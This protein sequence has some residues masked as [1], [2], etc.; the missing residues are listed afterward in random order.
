MVE[1]TKKSDLKAATESYEVLKDD[2]FPDLTIGLIHGRMKGEEKHAIMTDFRDGKL[3]IIAAT[4]VV[5]VGVDIPSATIMAVEHAERFGLS[6]LHQLRGR[7]GRSK[8][9]SYCFLLTGPKV[10]NEAKRRIEAMT[11][12]TNGFKI[13]EVDL[14]IRG[15]GEILGTKQ[16]GMPELRVASLTDSMLISLA[17]Q[18]AFDM[19]ADDPKLTKKENSYIKTIL[20]RRMGKKISYSNIG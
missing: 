11:G 14:E 8:Q 4:T 15:P 6:Q 13:A 9:K 10:S 12:T 20:K 2:I 7:V 17:R 16:S 3:D 1:E 18:L 5:E 19:I